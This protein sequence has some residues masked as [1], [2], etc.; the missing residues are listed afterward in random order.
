M[1]FRRLYHD[2]LAQA[3]YLIACQ[4]TGEAIVIDPLNDPVS[5]PRRGAAGGGADRDGQRDPRA[6]GFRLRRCRAR[7][8]GGRGT[9]AVGCRDRGRRATI[10][11]PS[12][13]RAG[14]ATATESSWAPVRLDVLH[15]PGHTPEHI[16]FLVTDRA[17]TDFPSGSSRVTSSSSATSGA[18]T[19]WSAPLA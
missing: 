19:C 15:V 14:F 16:A 1:L 6:R 9:S 17:T 13:T 8:C 10:V 3:A 7:E 18:P 5:L 4:R 2:R 12:R 11:P